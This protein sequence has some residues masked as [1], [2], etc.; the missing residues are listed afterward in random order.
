MNLAM[1]SEKRANTRYVVRRVAAYFIDVS[2]L[3][4]AVQGFQWG[5]AAATG[6]FPFNALAARNSG[7]LIYGWMLLTVS[8]PIWLYFV[9][10]ER[11]A[12]RATL[13]KRLLGLEVAATTG[14][15]VSWRQAFGRTV[16]KLLPWEIFHLAF[17]LPTPLLSDPAPGFRPGFVVG[18]VVLL[19]YLLVLIQPPSRQSIHDL[20]VGTL[21][22]ERPKS[23]A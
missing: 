19:L 16:L 15:S 14:E 5:L 23:A 6:G 4:L 12:W 22:A 9:L 1:R 17:M 3:A 11:S 13:G 18:A 20:I 7:W 8:L 10:L 2:L 21:V